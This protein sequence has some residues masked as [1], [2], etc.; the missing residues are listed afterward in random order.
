M[1]N[2]NFFKILAC[3]IAA[4]WV[5]SGCTS[6][7]T[8]P[9]GARLGDTITVAVGSADNMTLA[10]TTATFTPSGGSPVPLTIKSIVRLYPD[11]TAPAVSNPANSYW[12]LTSTSGHQ[13]WLSVLVIDL[14]TSGIPAPS[15]GFINVTTTADYPTI[16]DSASDVPIALEILT[17]P[18]SPHPLEYNIG[19][20]ATTIGNLRNIEQSHH[21]TVHPTSDPSATWPTYGAVEV[22]LEFTTDGAP[23]ASFQLIP[24]DISQFTGSS[25]NVIHK[26]SGDKLVVSFISPTGLMPYYEPR[27]SVI[28]LPARA[29]T[30]SP[31]GTMPTAAP[32]VTSVVHYDVDGNVV[33]GPSI[34][35]YTVVMN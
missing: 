19:L 28:P 30:R 26:V 3:G 14:P 17:G 13:P 2:M 10:N 23:P 31:P 34:S 25:R 8:L 5:I 21:V 20:G 22:T 7:T 6:I 9:T 33:A 11:Q 1:K 29:L 24:D 35:E 15:T 12:Q 4:I 32:V 27:F 16:A 18:G